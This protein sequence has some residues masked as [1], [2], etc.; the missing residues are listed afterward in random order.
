[1]SKI[2]FLLG[3][4]GLISI[5]TGAADYEAYAPPFNSGKA[6]RKSVSKLE[7][8]KVVATFK[9]SAVALR[10]FISGAPTFFSA[11]GKIRFGGIVLQYNRKAVNGIRPEGVENDEFTYTYT[12]IPGISQNFK[13]QNDGKVLSTLKAPSAIAMSSCRY[14]MAL[15]Y[16]LCSGAEVQFDDQTFQLPPFKEGANFSKKL[17][18]DNCKTITFNPDEP[19]RQFSITFLEPARVSATNSGG[20]YSLWITVVPTGKTD[21]FRYELNPGMV[22]VAD[23]TADT[24]SDRYL[25]KVGKYDFWREDRLRLPD[26]GGRRNLLSN[27][28][29]ELG[30]Q[31][32]WFE[33]A[34]GDVSRE[35]WETKP[36]SIDKKEAFV[37]NNSLRILSNQRRAGLRQVISA[38]AVL[39]EP[40]TYTVSFYAKTDHPG[41]QTIE[42]N[43]RMMAPGKNIWQSDTINIAAFKPTAEW[44]RYE[45]TIDIKVTQPHYFSLSAKS[46]EPAVCHIDA[47]QLERGNKA[48]AYEAAPVEGKLLTSTPDNF[49]EPGQSVNAQLEITTALPD[50]KGEVKTTVRDFFGKVI[51]SEKHAF[52]TDSNAKGIVKLDFE[53]TP[54]GI[55]TVENNYTIDGKERYE[56]TRFAV[57]HSLDNTHK[58]KNLFANAYIDPY[59]PV[60]YYPEVLERLRKIGIGSRG[61]YANTEKLVAEEAAKYGIDSLA[62]MALRPDRALVKDMKKPCVGF[63]VLPNIVWYQSLASG[64]RR[65]DYATITLP[66]PTPEALKALED[67]TARKSREQP[68]IKVWGS[69]NE[70]EGHMP[71]FANSRY[72]TEERFK[73]YVEVELASARGLK[74][75]NPDALIGNSSTS[76]L[77]DD[78]CETIDKLLTAIGGRFRYDCFIFHIYREA[79][80]YPDLDTDLQKMFKVLER[81]GYKNE[82]IFCPEGMHWKPYKMPNLFP[83][84]WV[85][86]TWG[87]MTY[88]I[89]HQERLSAAWRARTWLVGL[90]NAD[91]IKQMKSCTNFWSFELDCELTPFANQKI[92]N[93]LGRLLGDA[94]FVK[95]IKFSAKT[96]CYVFR[97]ARNRPVAALWSCDREM[98][99]GKLPGPMLNFIGKPDAELFDLMEVRYDLE[100]SLRLSPFPVFLRGKAGSTDEMISALENASLVIDGECAVA[101][102]IELKPP[103]HWALTLDNRSKENFA[104]DVTLNG[105]KMSVQLPPARQKTLTADLPAEI[106]ARQLSIES[107]RGEIRQ[108]QPRV[109]KTL[110]NQTLGAV[111]AEK[112]TFTADGAVDWS[113]APALP[114]NQRAGRGGE[115]YSAT[116]K[117][118]W[119]ENMFYMLV[120]VKD[121]KHVVNPYLHTVDGWR[122]DSLQLFF[123]TFADGHNLAGDKMALDDW[124]YG[125]YLESG[126]LRPVI[127]RHGVPDEQLTE[128]FNAPRPDTIAGNE[129]KCVFTKTGIGY[130]YELT[131]ALKALLPFQATAG[132]MMGIGVLLNNQ[133]STEAMPQNRLFWSI[134]NELPNNRPDTWPIVI[135]AE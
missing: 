57:M 97:D 64:F 23:E 29:F 135:L 130:R 49:L 47:I 134:D 76:R 80:E 56:F 106:S 121:P 52:V 77:G 26:R 25:T 41:K 7:K 128:G 93:T 98:D 28:S 1:M 108:A 86:T 115:N 81:H 129:V 37:G 63:T 119:A 48:T 99:N 5:A 43:N 31:S 50:V 6:V 12:D 102:G 54:V 22:T 15:R 59:S 34:A 133:D 66:D 42:L 123:D 30:I 96:R 89:G 72:A 88:D 17:F 9:G 95:E 21:T 85:A 11:D 69:I 132:K 51:H 53:K 116:L 33:N 14:E 18:N 38:H 131:F 100:K 71:E 104:G 35:A 127:Y 90:K 73:Q 105:K 124:A 101:L 83:V 112:A 111:L 125:I 55:F 39:L 67:A 60:Q 122:N 120:D 74:R 110:I 46:N 87:P 94:D 65:E 107:L 16:E 40:G 82:P 58:H 10:C 19:E 79:P 126:T 114:I 45:R 2:H 75:G 84:S 44:K 36:V 92:S 3:I 8:G 24:A 78:R 118:A 109:E 103:F 32:W 113:K 13:L 27:S 20:N 70:A 117:L 91:R 4:C 61:A 68:W 62:V